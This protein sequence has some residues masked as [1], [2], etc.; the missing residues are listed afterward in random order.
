MFQSLQRSKKSQHVS[1]IRN[2]IR[3]LVLIFS[4][5][6]HARLS[7][8]VEHLYPVTNNTA[9]QGGTRLIPANLMTPELMAAVS[10]DPVVST[11]LAHLI[12]FAGADTV[13]MKLDIEVRTPR[14]NI[15]GLDNDTGV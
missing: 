12:T 2:P 6:N 4:A 9:N 8:Q 5:I 1:F 7:D 3:C 13:I 15:V 11:T 10:G 14:A